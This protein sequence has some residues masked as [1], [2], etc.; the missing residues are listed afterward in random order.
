MLLLLVNL[1]LC[2]LLLILGCSVTLNTFEELASLIEQ[3]ATKVKRNEAGC[4]KQILRIK[5]GYNYGKN[6]NLGDADYTYRDVKV[7]VLI[8]DQD[9]RKQ[10]IGEIQFLLEYMLIAKK[11]NHSVYTVFRRQEFV[12]NV[13]RIVND[14]DRGGIGVSDEISELK[15]NTQ[16]G[17]VDFDSFN[18][19][20]LPNKLLFESESIMEPQL[21]L[22][23]KVNGGN[24]IG[25]TSDREK[26][27]LL[28]HTIVRKLW[29]ASGLIFSNIFHFDYSN[30]YNGKYISNYINFANMII[31]NKDK[32]MFY[33]IDL[34]LISNNS[35][36]NDERLHLISNFLKC[37]YFEPFS[38]NNIVYRC[39]KYNL[40]SFL[41]LLVKYRS[42]DSGM[43]NG[44]NYV[45]NDFGFTP[46]MKLILSDYC[47]E[48]WMRLLFNFKEIDFEIECQNKFENYF[49]KKVYQFEQFEKYKAIYQRFRAIYQF[50]IKKTKTNTKTKSKNKRSDIQRR[51]TNLLRRDTDLLG[52]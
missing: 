51:E 21:I 18:W 8:S 38:D 35:N 9:N 27:P 20:E 48:E 1:L 32:Q 4:I 36:E 44:I 42:S 40:F 17:G 45:D 22:D 7:N 37:Q 14:H 30:E 39:V 19:D 31:L 52:I 24:R 43:K 50:N 15:E 49:N 33:G 29:K 16:S 6:K 11:L 2:L 34:S 46:F 12:D 28:Y 25:K 5:N 10:L 26:C 23:N 13:K 3:L 47:D 41:K